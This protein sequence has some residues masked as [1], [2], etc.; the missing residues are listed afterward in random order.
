MIDYRANFETE[1]LTF[2]NVKVPWSE[3]RNEAVAS[4]MDVTRLRRLSI[5]LLS[6]SAGD[7]NEIALGGLGLY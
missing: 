6:E 4:E 7:L 2:A 3:F 5:E 1:A